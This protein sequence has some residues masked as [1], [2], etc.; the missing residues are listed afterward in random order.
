ML[1][2]SH[3][4]LHL[5][6]RRAGSKTCPTTHDSLN[7]MSAESAVDVADVAKRARRAAL[8]MAVLDTATKNDALRRIRDLLKMRKED[9]LRANEKDKSRAEG[10]VPAQM[11][12][13]LLLGGDK[14]E[15]LLRGVDDVI[16]L[17][18]PVGNVSLRREL[19]HGL[20]LSRVACPIGV[21]CVIFEARPEAAVQIA[22]LAVKSGNAVI[23]KGGSE[24]AQSNRVL[25]D[26]MRDALKAASVP[27]DA[28][29]LVSSRED[30]RGLLKMDN[31]IDLVIPRGSRSLVRTIQQSTR[32]PVMGHA[33]GICSVYID[34]DADEEKARR[35]VV[36]AKTNYPAACNA[37][38]T[39]LIHE[40]S[41]P[42]LTTICGALKAAGVRLR[43][44]SKCAAALEKDMIA[45]AATDKDFETEFGCLEMAIK[46]VLSVDEAIEHINSHGSGH[47]DSIVTENRATAKRFMNAVDSAGV[48]HN[49]STRFADGFRYGFGAE[50]G[51]STNRIHARGPVGMEGLLT[52]KYKLLGDGHCVADYGKGK[53][54]YTHRD[55]SC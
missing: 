19:D 50:V 27:I 36:D 34:R 22:T 42:M 37:A 40:K 21:L 4:F 13:R 5:H 35:I 15:Q 47:T 9:V 30:V 12:K 3:L 41:I 54:A 39:L 49:A 51:V 32:I 33:D 8:K 25:V 38:E 48:Y 45:T 10:N 1:Q 28:V 11:F 31:F 43:A 44:D 14:F 53:R 6:F 16:T 17:K 7:I 23:L 2:C 18:D 46:C 26:A 52:Y 55:L 29:Q 20:T 24:A